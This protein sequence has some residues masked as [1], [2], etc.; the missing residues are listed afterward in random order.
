MFVAANVFGLRDRLVYSEGGWPRLRTSKF[1]KPNMSINWQII[2]GELF[3]FLLL[4]LLLVFGRESL[5]LVNAQGR[6]CL[7]VAVGVGV[8][9]GVTL[10]I[11]GRTFWMKST[12]AHIS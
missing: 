10:D 6:S 7:A 5:T 9:D 12:S 3:S 2:S 11:H 8:H 4:L 1:S